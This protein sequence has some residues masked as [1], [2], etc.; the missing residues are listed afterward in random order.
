MHIP[1]NAGYHLSQDDPAEMYQ[2][3]LRVSYLC[4]SAT[5]VYGSRCHVF[6]YSRG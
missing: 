1:D 2:Y 5:K 3:F 6:G 4:T